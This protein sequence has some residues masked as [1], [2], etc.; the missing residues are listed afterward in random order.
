[1]TFSLTVKRYL[2]QALAF[3]IES[4]FK[5]RIRQLEALI[6]SRRLSNLLKMFHMSWEGDTTVVLP[7]NPASGFRSVLMAVTSLERKD[8][9]D[10]VE[11]GERATWPKIQGIKCMTAIEQEIAASLNK[12]HSQ[13][14]IEHDQRPWATLN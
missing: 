11:K 9:L 3:L 4:E 5:H 10:L 13:L 8:F 2:P 12:I 14:S 7:M 6:P 1:M